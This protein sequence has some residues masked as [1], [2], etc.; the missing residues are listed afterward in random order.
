MAKRLEFISGYIYWHKNNRPEDVPSPVYSSVE[1]LYDEC[2][3][4]SHV[5]KKLVKKCNFNKA[6]LFTLGENVE[7]WD[8]NIAH[9]DTSY[10]S[11]ILFF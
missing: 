10:Q 5:I 2:V 11:A 6:C 3:F 4:F 9:V 7:E 8:D 1:G